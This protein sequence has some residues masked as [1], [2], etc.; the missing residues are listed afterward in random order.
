M[1]ELEI[2]SFDNVWDAIED[3]PAQAAM[4][5]IK[6]CL[7]D[8][9]TDVIEKSGWP[10]AV[11]ARNCGLTLP[12]LAELLQGR[13]SQFSLDAL[14]AVTASLGQRIQIGLVAA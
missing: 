8:Q 11:A 13:I 9:I 1:T 5:Q 2:H 6:S 7:M 12:R 3:T 10:V 14:V 4:M